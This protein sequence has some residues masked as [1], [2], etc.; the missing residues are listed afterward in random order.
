MSLVSNHLSRALI[1][2]IA[3][4]LASTLIRLREGILLVK[5]WIVLYW[6]LFERESLKL[7]GLP[8]ILLTN[9]AKEISGLQM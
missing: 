2:F 6:P 9:V 1:S 8:E 5:S 3:H 7:R 4:S